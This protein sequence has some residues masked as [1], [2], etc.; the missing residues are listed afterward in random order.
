M[1]TKLAVLG[2]V[3][4]MSGALVSCTPGEKGAVVGGITGAAIGGAVG[5]GTGAAIGGVTGA[6]AGSA[7]A[8]RRAYGRRW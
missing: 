2:I 8:K 5:D 6:I 4:G 7:I 1:K 3:A